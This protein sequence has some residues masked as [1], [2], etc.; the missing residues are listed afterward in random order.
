MASQPTPLTDDQK[1]FFLKYGYL[2]LTNCFT[3]DQAAE[4]CEGVWTRLGY[5]PTDKTTWTK[6]RINGLSLLWPK[7]K[8]GK[9]AAV[10]NVK[11]LHPYI[12]LYLAIKT[13]I[14]NMSEGKEHKKGGKG[15][16]Y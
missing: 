15:L 11:N 7:R 1:E 16:D 8:E 4:V 6:E 9:N 2:K 13:G 5:S 3:R 12:P 10:Q 14:N